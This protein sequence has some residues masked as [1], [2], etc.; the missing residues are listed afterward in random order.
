MVWAFRWGGSERAD[1]VSSGV[2]CCVCQCRYQRASVSALG[3]FKS[4]TPGS[5]GFPSM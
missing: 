1:V 2:K 3:E 5:I 4:N